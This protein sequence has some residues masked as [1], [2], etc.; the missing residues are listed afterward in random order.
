M[1]LMAMDWRVCMHVVHC[2][3]AELYGQCPASRAYCTAGPKIDLMETALA[4]CP[5]QRTARL[6]CIVIVIVLRL[7]YLS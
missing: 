6:C 4:T 5:L 1:W 3:D 7:F 2:I